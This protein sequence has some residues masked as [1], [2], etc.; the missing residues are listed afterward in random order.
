MV[1]SSIALTT[2]VAV[3]MGAIVLPL[4]ATRVSAQQNKQSETR[5]RSLDRKGDKQEARP[6]REVTRAPTFDVAPAAGGIAF[7]NVQKIFNES[8]RFG[9]FRDRIKRDMERADADIRA[10]RKEI[11]KLSNALKELETEKASKVAQDAI[12]Q[13]IADKHAATTGRSHGRNSQGFYRA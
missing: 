9:S 7:V 11:T 3:L 1:R 12:R 5:S 10:A 6:E 8:K 4:A 2:T 13:L